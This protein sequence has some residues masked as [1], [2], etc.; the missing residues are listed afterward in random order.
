MTQIQR[1]IDKMIIR[2]K[3][4]EPISGVRFVREYGTDKV[5]TPVRGMLAVVGITQSSRKKG[6]IGG[7][8]SS[9]IKGETFG[10]D[11][12]IRVYSPANENGTGLSEAVS[13]I[14]TGLEK[15]DEEKL[16]TESSAG[17]IEFDADMNAIF[18]TIKFSIEFCLCEEGYCEP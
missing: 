2:L 5:E 17:S 12:E 6:Y 16:I 3:H 11:V 18:R 1:Q 13:E 4:L 7:Y 9:G 8:L 10:A 14:L 15:A